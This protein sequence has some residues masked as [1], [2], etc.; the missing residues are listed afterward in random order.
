M[1]SRQTG[2][3]GGVLG[4]VLLS[5]FR[6]ALGVLLG[7]AGL[8]LLAWTVFWISAAHLWPNGKAGIHELLHAEWQAGAALVRR[9]GGSDSALTAPANGLYGLVFR[10][11]GVHDMGR[12][13]AQGAPLSIP[14]TVAR[15]TY[16]ARQNEIE[17]AMVGT[18]LLGIRAGILSRYLPLLGLLYLVGAVDGLSLRAV[19]RI[20]GGR[21]SAG[22]Y[23]RA[24]FMQLGLLALGGA[25]LLV[26]PWSVAWGWMAGLAAG[27]LAVL[28]AVQWT[29]YKK[30]L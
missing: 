26:W 8:L 22:V 14:D 30:H 15:D 29:Y 25:T 10:F 21:E 16:I 19:R 18:Q 24:K 28:A 23:H 2:F 27:H 13:F 7:L 17:V 9:Q 1:A 11:S 4:R 5:P 20:Q 12:R 6:V 3:D